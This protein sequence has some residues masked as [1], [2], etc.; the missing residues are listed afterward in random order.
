MFTGLVTFVLGEV[1]GGFVLAMT[2]LDYARVGIGAQALGIAQ[3][4]LELAVAFS[5][6]RK[7]FGQPI[8]NYQAVKVRF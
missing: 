2:Q 7:T 6:Q 1:G 3:A 5:K 4:A 8:S